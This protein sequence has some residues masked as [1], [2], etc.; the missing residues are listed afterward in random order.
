MLEDKLGMEEATYYRV[1][2]SAFVKVKT[3]LFFTR[4]YTQ[5]LKHHVLL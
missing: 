1:V 4:Y 3:K 2:Q 5:R